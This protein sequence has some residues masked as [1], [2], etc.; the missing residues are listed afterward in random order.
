[1]NTPSE[2]MRTVRST[3]WS[4]ERGKVKRT[5][6]TCKN[7]KVGKA[8]ASQNVFTYSISKRHDS[9]EREREKKRGLLEKRGPRGRF[10]AYEPPR[11]P[12]LHGLGRRGL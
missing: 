2:A 3:R 12:S 10:Y 11:D 7:M 5:I 4:S 1:M 6:V 9:D 8:V